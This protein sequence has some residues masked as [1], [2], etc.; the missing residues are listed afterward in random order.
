MLNQTWPG[1]EG[2]LLRNKQFRIA[3]SHVGRDAIKERAFFGLN[4]GAAQDLGVTVR[5][6]VGEIE[7]ADYK[8]LGGATGLARLPGAH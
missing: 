8:Y 6:Y 1:P 3:L 2:E 5:A 7:V 4:F